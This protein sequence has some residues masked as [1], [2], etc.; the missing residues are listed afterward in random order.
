QLLNGGESAFAGVDE[1]EAATSEL[2]RK[3]V[4]LGLEEGGVRS[5][6]PRRGERALV[7]IDAGDQRAE[8]AELGR[9]LARPARQV[10]DVLAPHL[11]EP[12]PD[13]GWKARCGRAN[14]AV[15]LVP[16]LPVLLGRPHQLACNTV[17][18]VLRPRPRSRRRRRASGRGSSPPGASRETPRRLR[19][20]RA[21]RAGPQG[22][23]PGSRRASARGSGSDRAPPCRRGRPKRR[24]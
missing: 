13:R 1:V 17:N 12:L 14:A 16:R 8:R 9:D 6:L 10:E 11:G 2:Q 5:L 15:A 7:G 21:R 19:R 18:T 22:S 23:A 4:Q 24:W 3:L 20:R